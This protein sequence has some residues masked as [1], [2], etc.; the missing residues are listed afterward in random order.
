MRTKLLV[1]ESYYSIHSI[2]ISLETKIQPETALAILSA[3]SSGLGALGSDSNH[4]V[5][6]PGRVYQMLSASMAEHI[7]KGHLGTWAAL[8]RTESL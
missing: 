2:P 4:S 3:S 5:R 8:L 1:P 7:H 6:F